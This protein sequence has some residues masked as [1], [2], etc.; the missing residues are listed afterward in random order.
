M[1]EAATD[2]TTSP[3]EDLP[4]PAPAPVSPVAALAAELLHLRGEHARLLDDLGR[5]RIRTLSEGASVARLA[6]NLTPTE[7][8]CLLPRLARFV[9]RLEAEAAQ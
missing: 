4:N 1:S 8:L 6:L 7:G 9:L 2:I 3:F 5:R